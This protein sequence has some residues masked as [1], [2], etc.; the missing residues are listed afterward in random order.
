MQSFQLNGARLNIFPNI[1]EL[2]QSLAEHFACLAKDAVKKKGLFAVSLAGGST[3]KSLY[4][5]LA[6][7]PYCNDVPWQQTHIFFGDE[8]CVPPSSPQSNYGMVQEIFLSK[9]AIPEPNI[10][11]PYLN[12]DPRQAA[13]TYDRLLQSFFG[14]AKRQLPIFDLVLL[15][16]GKD[17]HTASLFPGTTALKD[18]SHLF[19]AVYVQSLKSYRLTM[20]LPVI[21]SAANVIFMV[22]GSD[23]KEI[24]AQVRTA[25]PHTLPAQ[26]VSPTK[27]SLE[28][29]VDNHAAANLCV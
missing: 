3:P 12:N 19:I 6:Q 14:L 4:S 22:T 13:S 1:D 28:W 29:Y 23:K 2:S 27:G 18:K 21:N 26:F 9:V 10:H 25:T 17:G 8:R 5:L 24:L 7:P 15:G 16:L 20:T 11:A